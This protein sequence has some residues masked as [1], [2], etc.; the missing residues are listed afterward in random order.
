M[1][2]HGGNTVM[3]R[4]QPIMVGITVHHSGNT[5]HHGGDTAHHGGDKVH[6]FLENMKIEMPTVRKNRE[7]NA[8]I[9]LDISFFCFTTS[10][11][12]P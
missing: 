7:M 1:V 11:S 2:H 9:L 3:V 6:P 5:V 12:W 10:A 4:I 8:D